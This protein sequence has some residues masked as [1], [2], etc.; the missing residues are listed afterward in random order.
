[1]HDD[2]GRQ[3]AGEEPKVPHE[4]R[5]LYEPKTLRDIQSETLAHLANGSDVLLLARTGGGKTACVQLPAV[6]EWL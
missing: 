4:W 1:M 5:E 2:V 6:A 3:G